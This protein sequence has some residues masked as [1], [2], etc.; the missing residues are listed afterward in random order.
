MFQKNLLKAAMVARGYTVKSLALALGMNQATFYRKMQR[1]G[2]FTREEMNT[3]ITC[4]GLDT[5][6][7]KD[8]FFAE[9]LA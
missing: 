7:Y 9:E 6:E 2:D 8:I 1:D 3:M 5:S 4:L